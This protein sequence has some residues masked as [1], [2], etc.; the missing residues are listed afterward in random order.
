MDGKGLDPQ[1][2][3]MAYPYNFMGLP[4]EFSRPGSSRIA[5]IPVPYEATTTWIKGTA[6]GPDAIIRASC[7]LECYDIETNSEVFRLGIQTD[8]E[9]KASLPIELLGAI[10]RRVSYHLSE[11]RFPVLLGGEH[12][13]SIGGVRACSEAYP[14]LSVLHLD[15]HA[16]SRDVYENT[17]FSHACAMARIREI[18][19]NTV[20]VG[21]RSLDSSELKNLKNQKIFFA[22]QIQ[23]GDGWMEQVV[24]YLTDEVYITLDLDVLDPSIMPA[25]GTPEPGGMGWYQLLTL[26]RLVCKKRKIVGFD[27]VELCPM[28]LPWAEFTA[29]NVVYKTLS[30]IFANDD[31]CRPVQI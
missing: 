17:K 13:I 26:L 31:D 16:D 30:Y 18:V 25:T 1:R 6:G 10:S 4:D 3:E 15:A 28:N 21:I 7:N 29:A 5:I 19:S 12:T 23:S 2:T 20:S 27:T 24:D 8:E 9:I 14:N 11:G 22:H